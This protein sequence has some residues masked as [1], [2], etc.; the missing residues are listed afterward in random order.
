MALVAFP[1]PLWQAGRCCFAE[2]NLALAPAKAT[3]TLVGASGSA[4]PCLFSV[5]FPSESHHLGVAGRIARVGDVAS[6]GGCGGGVGGGHGA[7]WTA[8]FTRSL[9]DL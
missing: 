7:P 5:L 4:S 1:C 9:G 8:A 6:H 3:S 2:P